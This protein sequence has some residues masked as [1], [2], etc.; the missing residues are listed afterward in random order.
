MWTRYNPRV[1]MSD[2]PILLFY[3]ID[4]FPTN[5]HVIKLHPGFKSIRIFSQLDQSAPIFSGY[6]PPIFQS[7]KRKKLSSPSGSFKIEICNGRLTK[8]RNRT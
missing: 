3:I 4:S 2:F 6:I 5:R 7:Q 8:T 1:H